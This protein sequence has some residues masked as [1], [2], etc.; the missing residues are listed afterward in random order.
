[1]VAYAYTDALDYSGWLAVMLRD[2]GPIIGLDNNAFRVIWPEIRSLPGAAF[3]LG[4]ALSPYV[5]LLAKAAFEDRQVNLSEAARSLGLSPIQAF[6]RVVI[7]LARPALVAGGALV[8]M[9]CLADYGTVSFFSVQTLSTGL[10]KTW[11]GYGDRQAAALMG[12]G[13]LGLAIAILAWERLARGRAGFTGRPGQARP[14]LPLQGRARFWVPLVCGLGGTFG[15]LVPLLLL[16][17][18]AIASGAPV[19]LSRLTGQ[20]LQTGLYGL[21]ALAVILP[22]AIVLAY[23][24]RSRQPGLLS[25]ALQFAS[26]GYAVPGLVVAVG[27]LGWSAVFTQTAM[28]FFD[29]RITLTAT[30]LLLIGG[31]L[32]RFFTVGYS[33]VEVGL[34]A[35]DPKP[36]LVGA[37]PRAHALTGHLA[38]PLAN[39]ARECSGCGPSGLCGCCKGTSPDPGLEANERGDPRNRSASIC[40]RRTAR[41]GSLAVTGHCGRWTPSGVAARAQASP[42]T[43]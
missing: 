12:F 23:G 16:L 4:V 40:S 21:Y 39:S 13:M 9:E 30:S 2:L 37:Q 14:R 20:A 22:I 27:L 38:R 8:I 33:T 19:D 35:A 1:M 31:Y 42:L 17:R 34:R 10:F 32:T 11:F 18:A 25:R 29:W 41:R 15:F 26:S 5:G 28:A 6:Y 24:Q 36:R 43:D 3:V 7:P